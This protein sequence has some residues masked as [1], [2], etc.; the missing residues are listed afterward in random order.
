M[1]KRWNEKYDTSTP[2]LWRKRYS[3]AK[4]QAKHRFEEWAFEYREWY[5]MWIESGVSEHMGRQP[6]HYCMVRKDAIEAWSLK[7]CIIVPRRQF[8]KKTC[9]ETLLRMVPVTDWKDKHDVRYKK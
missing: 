4:S 6:H 5:D 9:Y 7:N 1:T 2:Y 8:M 3:M